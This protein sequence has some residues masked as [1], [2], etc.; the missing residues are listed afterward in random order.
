MYF[1]VGSV[2]I[3]KSKAH[4]GGATCI[5]LSSPRGC[6]YAKLLPNRNSASAWDLLALGV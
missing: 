6:F 2:S 4:W 1:L 3:S 5:S